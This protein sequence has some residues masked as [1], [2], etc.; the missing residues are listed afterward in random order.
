MGNKGDLVI[1]ETESYTRTFHPHNNK[2]C[3]HPVE[4]FLSKTLN[5]YQLT[6]AVALDKCFS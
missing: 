5:P 1:R 4:E 2:M 3:V 6:Q